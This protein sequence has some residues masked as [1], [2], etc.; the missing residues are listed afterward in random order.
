MTYEER[1]K[2]IIRET[3]IIEYLKAI[4]KAEIPEAWLA[5][6]ALRNIVWN[7]LYPGSTLTIKDI[8]VPYFSEDLQMNMNQTF[9]EKLKRIYP[10]GKWECD[11]QAHVNSETYPEFKNYL[12]NSPYH[13]IEESMKDFWFS[14]NTIGVRLNKNGEIEILNSE[15]LPDLF[16]GIL[17]VMPLQ[18]NNNEPWFLDKINRITFQCSSIKVIR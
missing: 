13:S 15:A 7:Y 4:Q 18:K 17:R 16:N 6:G 10:K 3:E 12:P 8:D 1:L 5:A 14:V 11:N 9:E 2:K